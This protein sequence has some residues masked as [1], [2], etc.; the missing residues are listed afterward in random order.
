[1]EPWCSITDGFVPERDRNTIY[2]EDAEI[3]ANVAKDGGQYILRLQAPR[4]AACA[5]PGQFV[6]VRV[7]DE[8]LMRRPISIMSAQPDRG[9]IDL[10]V[11]AVGEGTRLLSRR[12]TGES[13]SIL[14]PI[15]RGFKLSDTSKRYVCIGGGVGI[16]PMIFAAQHLRE[17]ADLTFFAG[18]EVPFPFALRPS[19][20]ILPGITGNTILAVSSLEEWGVA[21]RLASHA[22]FYGCFEGHVTDLAATYLAALD[23]GERTRCVILACGPHAML[24]AAAQLSRRFKVPAQLCLEEFMACGVGGCA[25]CVVKTVE[26]GKAYY[27]RVCVDGPV[28]PADTLPAFA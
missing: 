22:G 6:H 14:G 9:S 2:P 25:G 28:F 21:S 17:R 20:Y 3:L 27:R 8:R 13:V 12:R 5:V 23:E 11:K 24:H 16:P 26:S 10:L 15:G 18:S 4:T 19:T 7:S 1:M